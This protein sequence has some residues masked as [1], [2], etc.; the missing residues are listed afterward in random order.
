MKVGMSCLDSIGISMGE[1]DQL[2]REASFAHF[3]G[4]LDWRE[5]NGLIAQAE[6]PPMDHH[7]LLGFKISK[8]LGGFSRA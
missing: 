1:V 6:G 3:F 7:K 8:S 2:V 5:V 4:H